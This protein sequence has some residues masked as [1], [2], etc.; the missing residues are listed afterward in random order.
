METNEKLIVVTGGS[1]GIGRAVVSRFLRAGYP[2]AT[3]ARSAED[4]A[5]LTTALADEVPAGILH[6]RPADLSQAADCAAFAA[7]VLGLGQP[8][9]VLVN[10]AGAFVPGR[11]QDEPDDGSQL[12]QML[13]VNLL[14]AYDVT[15]PLLPG[16]LARGRGHIFTIC[17]TASITAYPNGGSYGIA[18]HAL[19]G[20]TKNLREEL[21]PS[22][23]RVT[24]VLP[25]P[26]LT[27]SWAGV[28]LPA[29]RFV[30]AEDV[31]EAVFGTYSLSPH[32]VV[33]EL[34]IRPQLGDL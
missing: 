10:N 30:Q 4:L 17:S 29:E 8:V 20:F 11:L 15:L 21:K 26:T 33:E 22:G 34:L 18:K 32:A 13:A 2:V 1:K 31:A 7:F 19:L 5:A 27:A 24:A 6:T 16:F 25:G 3:C 14:S 28:E 23:V 12:R 9:E